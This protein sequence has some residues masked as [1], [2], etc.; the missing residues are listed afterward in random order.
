MRKLLIGLGVVVAVLIVLA[1]AVPLIIPATVYRDQ[2][3]TAVQSATGRQLHITGPV[4]LTLLPNLAIEANDVAFDNMP[5][6]TAKEM[7]TLAKLQVGMRLFPLIGGN[8]QIDRFV[9]TDPVIH[10]EVGKDGRP[11]WHFTP[12]KATP[13]KAEPDAA[14]QTDSL[15]ELQLGEVKL[16]NGTVDYFDART[17]DRYAANQIGV[18]VSLPGLDEKSSVDGSVTWNGKPIKLSVTADRP[19]A[20]MGTGSSKL[21]VNVTSD[22]INLSF[23]G[24]ATGGTPQKLEGT[25][26]VD[27]SSVRSLATVAG[28]PPAIGGDGLGAFSL[29]GKLVS[30]G[31]NLTFSDIALTLDAIK[32][33]GNIAIDGNGAVPKL[34]GA[35]TVGMLD[36]NPYLARPAKAPTTAPVTPGPQ[37]PGQQMP[38]PPSP[39]A[40]PGQW[41]DAPIDLSALKGVDADL[42][43]AATGL[44]YEKIEIGKS[45]MAIALHGGKLTLGLNELQLYGGNGKGQVAV[46][47]SGAVPSLALSFA[48]TDIQAQPLLTAAIGLDRLTGTGQLNVDLSSRGRSQR[49]LI[50]ALSGKGSFGFAN[51]AIRGIDLVAMTKNVQQAFLQAATGGAQ[52]TTFAE[53]SGTFTAANGII[54]NDDLALK[55]PI[56]QVHGAGTVDLPHKAVDYRIE[57]DVSVNSQDIAVPIEIKGP[58]DKPSYQPDVNGILTKNAGKVLQGVIG[59]KGSN[60]GSNNPTKP[61]DLLKGL[62]GK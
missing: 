13:T 18:T 58:W 7:V 49:E 48:V 23:D 55:S 54:R 59:G 12:A 41:S 47:G 29:T 60:K 3:V 16:I 28:K 43:I 62:F 42:T 34:K 15:R 61:A 20:F 14:K 57:P 4:K 52:Q 21:K 51:G 40:A 19:R 5:G 26:S 56:I 22:L 6:G 27:A 38:P 9:M 53:L 25:L 39:P 35:L 37:A 36:L 8:V 10:L 31:P 45:A 30:V 24:T 11:N 44:R 50:G 32:A 1:V 33:G 17:N 46:D 2:I